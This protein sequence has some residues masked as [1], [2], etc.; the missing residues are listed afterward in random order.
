M[1]VRDASVCNTEDDP[2]RNLNDLIVNVSKQQGKID[3][4]GLLD[5]FGQRKLKAPLKDVSDGSLLRFNG[6]S[7]AI[8]G[9]LLKQR[10]G[11]QVIR[12]RLQAN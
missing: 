12:F 9:Y 5:D 10:F 1:T 4:R 8:I 2:I 7:K 3:L 6:R 11:P